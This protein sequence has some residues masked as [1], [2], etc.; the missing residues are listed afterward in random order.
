LRSFPQSEPLLFFGT[1]PFSLSVR[2]RIHF[3][4]LKRPGLRFFLGHFAPGF[5]FFQSVRVPF[6]CSFPLQC[7]LRQL[8][9][10]FLSVRTELFFF[11]FSGCVRIAF[12]LSRETETSSCLPFGPREVF[13]F[14]RESPPRIRGTLSPRSGAPPFLVQKR[15]SVQGF[16]PPL[17]IILL[18]SVYDIE[19]LCSRKGPNSPEI[20][21]GP[22]LFSLLRIS[23]YQFPPGPPPFLTLRW[24]AFWRHV[25]SASFSF[26][27]NRTPPSSQNARL[28]F[29]KPGAVRLTLRE[30]F[31]FPSKVVLFS[32]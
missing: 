15:V 32:C 12:F 17:T 4:P 10:L 1:F 30:L 23:P 5:S 7:R 9:L 26:V 24:R 2:T 29:L 25:V 6:L 8:G 22:P 3:P 13:F 20:F 19:P 11:F 21:A 14:R 27:S 31:L 16:V 28:S 18:P